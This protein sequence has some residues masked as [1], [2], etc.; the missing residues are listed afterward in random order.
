MTPELVEL[1]C[2][3][4]QIKA[5]DKWNGELPQVASGAVLFIQIPSGAPAR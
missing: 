3:E 5:I 2:V 1:R 4:A